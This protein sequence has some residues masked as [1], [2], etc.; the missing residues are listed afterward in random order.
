[1][2][3]VLHSHAPYL[4]GDP[5][6]GF[7]GCFKG[8]WFFFRKRCDIVFGMDLLPIDARLAEISSLL[9]KSPNLILTAEPGAGKTT[10]VPP[11][12]LEHVQ[13]QI[14]VL[15]PRRMAAVAACH[16]VCEERGWQVGREAGYLVRFESKYS[17]ATRLIFMT[18]AMLLRRIL[19]DPEL[20]GVGMV[21]IDEF[22]ERN[23]NQDLILGYVKE[24]QELGSAIKMVVMSATLNVTKMQ[25]YLPESSIIDVEGRSFPLTIEHQTESLSLRTDHDFYD[26]VSG[27][28]AYGL[29]KTEG[30]ILVFM[31]GVGE[32]E[33]AR[34]RLP[35]MK[36]VDI[37]VLHGS[38]QLRE[39]QQVLRAAG[40]RRVILSTNVAEASVTVNGVDCVVDT[41]IAKVMH[42]HLRTGFSQLELQRISLFNAKQRAGRSARQRPGLALRLWTSHEENTQALEPLA[43]CQRVD[44]AQTLLWLAKLGVTRFEQFSWLDHP[45]GKLLDFA[46]RSLLWIGAI[47]KENRITPLGEKLI[48]YPLPPRWGSLLALGEERG[49]G[50]TAARMAAIL[51]ERDFVNG[52]IHSPIPCDLWTRLESLSEGRGRGAESILQSARQLEGL[53]RGGDKKP[54][55]IDVQRLLL[56]S[57]GDRLCRRRGEGD[58]ALMTGQ[59]GVRL[60]KDSQV[61]KSEFFVALQGVDLPGQA[62]TLITLASG[63][64]KDFVLQ[65]LKDKIATSSDV[66]FD[67]DKEQF[68][69]RRGRFVFDLPID[70]PTL[71]PVDAADVTEAMADEL[72][73]MWD[74][75]PSRHEGLGRLMARWKFLLQH[76]PE[77]AEHLTE[78]KIRE[79]LSMAGYG[80]V[81]L[82][83]VLEKDLPGFIRTALGREASSVL[84]KEVPESLTAPS[85]HSHKIDYSE[86]HSAYVDVRLQEM[87][88][89]TQTPRVA[90][91]KVPLTFRLLGPNYRPVQVTSDLANFWK[92]AYVDV[93]KELRARYPKH[94]WPDDPLSAKPEAKGRRR[95]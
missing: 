91:G 80:S 81:S 33:R 40:R 78:D 12:L 28:V 1:M 59:R 31:P 88:G 10:R 24:Q 17:T 73:K 5:F 67:R 19:E 49:L 70:Q 18:D 85:G 75:L 8:T 27:A 43:E 79:A 35:M 16:R 82:K 95:H 45:P 6:I 25:R 51:S 54:E 11:F 32:I 56:L 93:R 86:M 92:S 84:D 22:H 37:A 64:E 44:L 47:D 60:S 71:T 89:L 55:L 7:P 83:Q 42:C 38:L 87:F 77:F 58:K 63:F 65:N 74:V 61:Q 50:K 76:K 48:S 53:V 21:I 36:D 13:G 52:P 3:E 62:D 20:S 41:G 66:Y 26:R 39:Q 14:L 69:A 4:P 34:D 2:G 23:L 9:G 68:F 94:S 72:W 46:R 15:Q 29:K 57:Q 90:F 30:D